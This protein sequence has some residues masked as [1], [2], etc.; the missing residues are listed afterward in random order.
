MKFREAV[1]NCKVRGFIARPFY[2]A[3]IPNNFKFWKNHNAP[4]ECR[5]AWQDQIEHDWQ[6]F[7]PEAGESSIAA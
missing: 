4:L 3:D 7:D 6:H 2:H 1:N 5:V